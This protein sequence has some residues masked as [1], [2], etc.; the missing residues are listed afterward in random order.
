M[1]GRSSDS[2]PDLNRAPSV[3]YGVKYINL[4]S[5]APLPGLREEGAYNQVPIDEADE[6]DASML[7]APGVLQLSLCSFLTKALI[8][9]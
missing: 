3:L 4:V 8:N 6:W 2:H 9:H 5:P 7:E 1:F